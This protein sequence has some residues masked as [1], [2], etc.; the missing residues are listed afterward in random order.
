MEWNRDLRL[1]VYYLLYV[2]GVALVVISRVTT[3]IEYN[4]AMSIATAILAI[5]FIIDV[6]YALHQ[7]NMKKAIVYSLLTLLLIALLIIMKMYNL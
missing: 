4:L 7:K 3:W 2:I 1:K 5:T 6:V